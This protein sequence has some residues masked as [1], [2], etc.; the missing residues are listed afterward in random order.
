MTS[1]S[2]IEKKIQTQRT[3]T[4]IYFT[5]LRQIKIQ[6]HNNA[7]IVEQIHYCGFIGI[8]ILFVPRGKLQNRSVI[9]ILF[10]R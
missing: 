9:N 10:I 2:K 5:L 1:Q 4:Y 7:Y 6:T 8:K 3:L